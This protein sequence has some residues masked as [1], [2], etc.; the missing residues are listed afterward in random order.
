MHCGWRRWPVQ[1]Q[2]W[3]YLVFPSELH[4]LSIFIN[5]SLTLKNVCSPFMRYKVQEISF[6]GKLQDG[7]F[8]Y[9]CIPGIQQR[10]WCTSDTFSKYLL[11]EWLINQS[12]YYHL[13]SQYL[14]TFVYFFLLHRPKTAELCHSFSPLIYFLVYIAI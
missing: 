5:A 10:S 1:F 4:I 2:V 13:D 7:D 12:P 6:E 9:C 14:C 11:N 3:G 8:I